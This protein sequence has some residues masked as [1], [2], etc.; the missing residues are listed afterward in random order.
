MELIHG[1]QRITDT[2]QVELYRGLWE[3]LWNVAV[4]GDDAVALIREG[5]R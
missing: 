3:R 2:A 4:V 1:E 5:G